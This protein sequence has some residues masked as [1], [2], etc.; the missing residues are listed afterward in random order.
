MSEDLILDI[1]KYISSK[2][3]SEITGY[4]QDY[5][6]QLA[7]GGNIDAQRIGGLWY[8]S[9]ES[10][11]S[12]KE[13][14]EDFKPTPPTAIQKFSPDAEALVYFDGRE[15]IS[16][17]R[18][19]KLTG[20]HKDYVG[21]L[22]RSGK[23]ISRQVGN[24]WYVDRGGILLHKEEK[25]ALLA[26]VQVES[27]G[28][29][30]QEHPAHISETKLEYG[31]ILTYSNDKADLLPLIQEGEE[32]LHDSTSSGSNNVPIRVLQ[33]AY[34][35]GSKVEY[36]HKNKSSGKNT[37]INLHLFVSLAVIFIV[38]I[39]FFSVHIGAIYTT[40]DVLREATPSV[41][42]T[43][44]QNSSLT[45]SASRSVEFFMTT[46]ENFLTTELVYRRS[47]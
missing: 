30:T 32:I 46:V 39:G 24:R 5:I 26:S 40:R 8:I 7:R 41:L 6:G 13:K 23:V 45:A 10:L 36:I 1:D 47:Q 43:T 38:L 27:V 22:A 4:T 21:Q 20:Y 44:Q 9:L 19:S 17:S 35:G 29:N 18:A 3:A 34:R 12:H 37:N 31:P 11:S 16:A 33:S 14:A 42:P 25:D 28:I 2:Q 15:Y